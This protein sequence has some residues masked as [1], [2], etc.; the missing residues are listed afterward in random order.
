MNLKI[1]F[2][3]LFSIMIQKEDNWKWESMELQKD[4]RIDAIADFGNGVIVIGTR[5]PQPGNIYRST[6]YGKSWNKI[7]NITKNDYITCVA[8]N[9]KGTGYILTGDK[10]NVWKTDDYGAS[11]KDLGSISKGKN[12]EG[13]G[14]A[15]GM[16]VTEKGTVLVSD[17]NTDG[18]QIFRSV[19]EGR[20]W[21]ASGK[22][23]DRAL[24][25]LQEVGDGIIIN[26]W[27]GNVYK[28]I[29]D[30]KTWLDMGKLMDSPL[31]GIE[32]LGN[33]EVIIGTESGNIFKS[34]NNGEN[35]KDLGVLGV[36][37]AVDDF[38][39]YGDKNIV[40]TTYTKGNKIFISNDNGNTWSD[41]GT[42][43]TPDKKDWF[44]HVIAVKDRDVEIVIGG[45]K[46]GYVLRH[47]IN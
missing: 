11:W 38:A 25:R 8:S 41:I 27:A 18:G 10:I 39:Y 20:N 4:G 46:M 2:L 1:V 23:S 14:N 13:F 45:T 33:N 42:T 30:G 3:A 34:I 47:E 29:D 9:K 24:Y 31:Y 7:V 26:G 28:S 35:W 36:G 6:D 19:D 32:Y 22:I 15:Y 17:A 40:C 12:T 21:A 43:G 16:V 5:R 37:G 44:D